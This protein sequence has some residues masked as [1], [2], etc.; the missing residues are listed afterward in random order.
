MLDCIITFIILLALALLVFFSYIELTKYL[1]YEHDQIS[2]NIDIDIEN[3]VSKRENNDPDKDGKM[4]FSYI[5][6]PNYTKHILDN[7]Y[8]DDDIKVNGNRLIYHPLQ[9]KKRGYLSKIAYNYWGP[10]EIRDYNNYY[11]DYE[12]KTKSNYYYDTTGIRL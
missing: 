7:Y 4:D 3:F 1:E 2:K 5:Y 11:G 9:F 10:Y 8:I 6:N 12:N